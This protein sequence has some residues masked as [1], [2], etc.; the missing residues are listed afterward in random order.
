MHRLGHHLG[1]LGLDAARVQ[2]VRDQAVLGM[3]LGVQELGEAADGEL[4]GLVGRHGRLH[5]V[6][7]DARHVDDGL[8]LRLEQQRQEEAAREVSAVDVDIPR[9]PPVKVPSGLGLLAL[10]TVLCVC[11]M[12]SGRLTIPLDR[13]LLYAPMPEDTQ[14]C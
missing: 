2:G 5:L 7:A 4:G 12:R 6:A 9:L 11:M 8:E 13:C 1:Q 14:H 3:V 10:H